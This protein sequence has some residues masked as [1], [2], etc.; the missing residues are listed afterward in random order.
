MFNLHLEEY[1]SYRIKI[2]YFEN[3]ICEY[4]LLG[5]MLWKAK[6]YLFLKVLE[7]VLHSFCLIFRFICFFFS[8][9]V[10]DESEICLSLHHQTAMQCQLWKDWLVVK[11]LFP[12]N[13]YTISMVLKPRSCLTCSYVVCDHRVCAEGSSSIITNLI[14]LYFSCI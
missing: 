14:F 8:V 11:D 1:L 13:F 5:E 9:A 10:P 2:R 7:I 6:Y 12:F 3:W 4:R